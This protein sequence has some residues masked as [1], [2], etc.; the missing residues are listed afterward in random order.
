MDH[1]SLHGPNRGRRMRVGLI[2]PPWLPVPPTVY[3]GTELVIDLL[4]RAL[5]ATGCEVTLVATGDSTCPV[6]RRWLHERSLGTGGGDELLEVSHVEHAYRALAGVDVIHDHTE[7]G[8]LRT[9]L[10]PPGTPIVTTVHGP[11]TPAAIERYRA[12]AA[13]G[14]EVV[15]ISHEQVRSAPT[16]PFR[17]VIHHGVDVEAFPLGS[18]DGG[19]VLFLGRMS[20]D[21]G[22]HRAIE[23]ARAA[24]RRILLAAKMWDADEHRYFAER[25]EPMLGEDAVFL[26]AVAGVQKLELLAG[27][28][29]L[30]N[31]IRWP[32]PFGLVMIEALACGTPVLSFAAGA[33]PEIVEHGRT[34]F[35]CA[36]EADMVRALDEVRGLDRAACRA[37]AQS[38]FSADRMALDHLR[39]YGELLADPIDLRRTS[40][41]PCGGSERE[42][43]APARAEV[44]VA[45]VV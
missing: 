31:P 40:T 1:T 38:R 12:A 34:G 3:G 14:V 37:S 13:G 11:T 4:A 32:E 26:G 21:K 29:A 43:G 45:R 5:Q 30:L 16:V 9:D 2:A 17:T 10:H 22:P 15:A 23:I 36:D 42:R 44:P 18:G 6:D 8:P 24:G 39:L 20:P 28:E 7:L 33:A 35:L 25:V 27:A 19:Y 41:G